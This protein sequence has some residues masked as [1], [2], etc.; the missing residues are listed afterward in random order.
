[1]T[2][3]K[4]NTIRGDLLIMLQSASKRTGG[5]TA[6]DLTN[7]VVKETKGGTRIAFTLTHEGGKRLDKEGDAA[8]GRL[9]S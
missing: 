2:K 8:R 1:M 6:I 4:A 5:I 7:V 9:I 3:P